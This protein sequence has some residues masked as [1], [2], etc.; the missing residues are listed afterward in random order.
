MA[1]CLAKLLGLGWLSVKSSVYSCGPVL[2]CWLPLL[3]AYAQPRRDS[4]ATRKNHDT[5]YDPY[6]PDWCDS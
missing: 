4:L 6:T 2:S 3:A 1:Y 5:V